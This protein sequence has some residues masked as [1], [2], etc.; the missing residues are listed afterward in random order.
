MEDAAGVMVSGQMQQ[1]GPFH[2]VAIVTVP[3]VLHGPLFDHRS[4]R[5][6]WAGIGIKADANGML[7]A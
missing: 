6:A 7:P 1:R 3:A 5:S 2:D 4:G